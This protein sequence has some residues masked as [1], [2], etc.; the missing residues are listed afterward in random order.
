LPEFEKKLK[1][2]LDVSYQEVKVIVLAYYDL[3]EYAEVCSRHAKL[4]PCSEYQLINHPRK[5]T[6]NS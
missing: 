5:D 4:E 3:G 6:R 2:R 1:E